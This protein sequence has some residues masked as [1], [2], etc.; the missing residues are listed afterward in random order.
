MKTT[1]QLIY[2]HGF[3]SSP[4]SHKAKVLQA[5]MQEKGLD[6][7]LQVPEIP[8][9]PV[10]A[11]EMLTNC[12]EKAQTSYNVAF[13]GSSLGGFYATWLAEHFGGKAV[14]VNPAVRPHVLLEKYLG[15]NVNYYTSE[16]WVLNQTHIQQFRDLD[17]EK[18]TQPERYLVKLQTGDE[19]LDYQLAVD[20][21]AGC[22]VEI[23]A[24]GD[25][26]FTNFEQHIDSLLDF[27][28]ISD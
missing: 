12:V 17:V 10:E 8:P 6:Q 1:T 9:V 4:E 7:Y 24:G 13:A 3:N 25:H 15:E 20:K 16:K 19:T 21:Y 2:L 14:L 28:G 22:H 5:A 27:C 23:E 26:S 18:I 11:I